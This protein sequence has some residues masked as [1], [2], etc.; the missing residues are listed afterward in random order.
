[1]EGTEKYKE[2]GR[3]CLNLYNEY[4]QTQINLDKK[5]LFQLGFR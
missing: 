3:E 4:Y 1:M 2:I 5:A